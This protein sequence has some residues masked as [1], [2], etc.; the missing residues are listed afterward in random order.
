MWHNVGVLWLLRTG[1]TLD[2]K[3]VV[4]IIVTEFNRSDIH[5]ENPRYSLM[6][7]VLK[8]HSFSNIKVTFALPDVTHSQISFQKVKYEG[9]LINP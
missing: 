4:D 8:C 2:K 1:I 9:A 7:S 3:P 5:N 6:F